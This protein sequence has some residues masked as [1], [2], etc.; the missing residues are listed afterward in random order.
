VTCHHR[1]YVCSR[2]CGSALAVVDRTFGAFAVPR[3]CF[4]PITAPQQGLNNSQQS[5]VYSSA[6]HT[7][8][9]HTHHSPSLDASSAASLS[10]PLET[11]RATK[12][13]GSTQSLQ[14]HGAVVFAMTRPVRESTYA[15]HTRFSHPT[16]CADEQNAA[17][18]YR[19]AALWLISQW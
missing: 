14:G 7:E 3:A 11:W 15:L 10:W 18:A 4:R 5:G 2:P 12:S 19:P 1:F 6:A 8:M 17:S 13:S 16:L 9:L